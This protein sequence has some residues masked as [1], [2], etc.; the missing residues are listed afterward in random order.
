MSRPPQP[1][2]LT[3]L[4]ASE[5]QPASFEAR[6]VQTRAFRREESPMVIGLTGP[7]SIRHARANALLASVLV[8]TA[9]FA[10]KRE[11]KAKDDDDDEEERP[12]AGA[13]AAAL[14]PTAGSAAV[15]TAAGPSVTS[16]MPRVAQSAVTWN[17]DAA[18]A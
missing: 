6:G 1:D 4:G 11:S 10:C 7:R 3:P 5:S 16:S 13:T 8:L 18:S 12:K 14:A 2:E 15:G 17:F 9:L